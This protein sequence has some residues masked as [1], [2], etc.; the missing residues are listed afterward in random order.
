MSGHGG[1][2]NGIF[3]NRFLTRVGYR[4]CATPRM[5]AAEAGPMPGAGASVDGLATKEV[6]VMAERYQIIYLHLSDGRTL[7]ATIKEFCKEGD[8]LYLHP[9]L[10]VTEP[11]EMPADCHW[12]TLKSEKQLELMG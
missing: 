12:S 11:R 7:Q 3:I 10:E 1:E 8:K 2:N 9:Q 5:V 4:P 6:D